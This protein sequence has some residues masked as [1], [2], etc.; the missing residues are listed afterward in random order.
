MKM[1]KLR[2]LV[3]AI[4][5]FSLS[6]VIFIANPPNLGIS[7]FAYTQGLMPSA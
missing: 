7:A 4:A 5:A 2:L 1:T 3:M 6:L